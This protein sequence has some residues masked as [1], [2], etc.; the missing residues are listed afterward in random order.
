MGPVVQR[1]IQGNYMKS[2]ELRKLSD[3]ATPAQLHQTCNPPTGYAW[4]N[5][6]D[7]NGRPFNDLQSRMNEHDTRLVA[8]LWNHRE[9]FAALIDAADSLVRSCDTGER[10]PDG[11]QRGIRHPD[12]DSIEQAREALKPFAK[13]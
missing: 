10:N 3:A 7:I 6:T 5:F 9:H 13:D 12:K 11:T 1:T 8:Y 4:L 2:D